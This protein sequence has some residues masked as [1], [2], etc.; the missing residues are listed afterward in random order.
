MPMRFSRQ[1]PDRQERR[2]HSDGRD[3][4]K[5][6]QENSDAPRFNKRLKV[7]A[8]RDVVSYLKA[9]KEWDGR[10]RQRTDFA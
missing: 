2:K 9:S 7:S 10:R 3:A 6:I 4:A 8:A 5:F 1:T